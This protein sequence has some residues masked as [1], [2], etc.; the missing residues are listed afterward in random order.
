[1]EN[2]IKLLVEYQTYDGQ[3]KAIDDKF[4]QSEEYKKYFYA[5]KFLSTVKDSLANLDVKAKLLNDNYKGKSNEVLKLNG[6]ILK[7]SEKVES[8]K[9]DEEL[10]VLQKELQ[11]LIS[12]LEKLEG[13][14]KQI[15]KETDDVL[16]E[17][18]RLGKETAENKANY[19]TYGE[20]CQ[21][22]K[23]E[24][25]Q[26]VEKL[27][28]K[29]EDIKKGI[30]PKLMSVYSAR[31]S[32]KKFPIIYEVN[33]DKNSYCPACATGL[34]ITAIDELQKGGIKVCE[35]CGKLLYAKN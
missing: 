21:Q 26:E 19:K 18:V 22:I 6:E 17:L 12:T 16:K 11:L 29:L 14:I 15:A 4:L 24:N 32:D 31:R 10:E 28:T 23:V 5:K 35:T 3:L 2:Q 27:K 34:S 30:D 25:A 33:I 7:C 1:M 9:T 20:K 13:E 8:C